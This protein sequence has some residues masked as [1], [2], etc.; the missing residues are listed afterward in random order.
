MLRLGRGGLRFAGGRAGQFAR[1][2]LLD[3]EKSR[4]DSLSRKAGQRLIGARMP[5]EKRPRQNVLRY[6]R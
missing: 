6:E 1:G 5:R 3:Q 2:A 4:W